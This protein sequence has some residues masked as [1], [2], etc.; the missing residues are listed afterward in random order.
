MEIDQIISVATHVIAIASVIAAI[1]PTPVDNGA[2]IVL[3]K[4]LDYLA[5]NVG[6]AKNA[7]QVEAD[8]LNR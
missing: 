4:V 6:G 8:K 7:A 3:R 2:L 1:T 5:L